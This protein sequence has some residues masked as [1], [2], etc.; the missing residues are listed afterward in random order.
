[1]ILKT[2][3]AVHHL[4][5]NKK[6]GLK[7]QINTQGEL[8]EFEEENITL[9]LSWLEKTKLDYTKYTFWKK[10]H[11]KHFFDVWSWAGEI[12]DEQL[13]NPYFV[14][15][16]S[17]SNELSKLE[18]DMSTWIEFNSYKP[19]EFLARFHLRLITIH[20]FFNGN[21]RITRIL[22]E[23]IAEKNNWAIPTWGQ[24]F[25]NKP[26]IRRQK[27]IEALDNARQEREI[28][29]IINFMFS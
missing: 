29:S 10:A 3:M 26:K 20:P 16:G 28:K 27:Y 8:D 14:E 17:I 1:L 12:R 11:K 24:N 19:K 15:P 6:K 13:N 5:I 18:K 21:G 9:G 22:T 23:Y 2:E 4:Q 25:S 7:Y